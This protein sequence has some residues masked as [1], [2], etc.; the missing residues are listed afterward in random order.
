[1][2]FP[3]LNISWNKLLSE[4]AKAGILLDWLLSARSIG[5]TVIVSLGLSTS[6]VLIFNSLLCLLHWNF[7][8]GLLSLFLWDLRLRGGGAVCVEYL[9][10]LGNCLGRAPFRNLGNFYSTW[11][12]LFILK[13][14]A[15]IKCNCTHKNNSFDLFKRFCGFWF[16]RNINK[17]LF[18]IKKKRLRDDYFIRIEVF[19]VFKRMHLVI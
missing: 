16:F 8:G 14:Y 17:F 13:E 6:S 5:S 11:K 2:L 9:G 10:Q 7:L 4:L 19:S 18:W 3:L 12:L 15:H 1:M